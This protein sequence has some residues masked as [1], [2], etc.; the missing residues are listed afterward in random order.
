VWSVTAQPVKCRVLRGI[1]FALVA[2]ICV[3]T[4]AANVYLPLHYAAVMP[5]H[6]EP[7]TGRVYKIPAR[8]GGEIFINA[9][10]RRLRE[11]VDVDLMTLLGVTM[12]LNFGLGTWLGWWH[13]APNPDFRSPKYRP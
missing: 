1:S 13:L 5:R 11:F 6:P 8:G 4:V 2:T 7:Q 3:V 9:H 12:V 10:E